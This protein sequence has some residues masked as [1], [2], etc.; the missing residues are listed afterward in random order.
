MNE[1]DTPKRWSCFSCCP[2][3]H[4]EE[5]SSSREGRIQVQ[6]VANMPALPIVSAESPV[7]TQPGE[8]F[9]AA[10]DAI[11]NLPDATTS[12]R[13]AGSQ[14][15]KSARTAGSREDIIGSR[16]VGCVNM[17]SPMGVQP[18]SFKKDFLQRCQDSMFD[19]TG[20]YAGAVKQR[21]EENYGRDNLR[22]FKIFSIVNFII[23]EYIK[24]H[25]DLSPE[26]VSEYNKIKKTLGD[27]LKTDPLNGKSFFSN[28]RSDA[29]LTKLK[30]M[31][32]AMKKCIDILFYK[33]D[34]GPGD[35]MLREFVLDFI[36]YF[37]F[38]KDVEKI[39]KI[40]NRIGVLKFLIS[41]YIHALNSGRD[42]RINCF[43]R[44]NDRKYIDNLAQELEFIRDYVEHLVMIETFS[45]DVLAIERYVNEL[46]AVP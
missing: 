21:F 8:R 1:I 9:A 42:L 26:G 36:L 16:S 6:S 38:S 35:F 15:G 43:T 23:I 17:L 31:A 19:L 39:A 41:P 22:D 3:S 24:R 33:N 40:S 37:N 2:L 32:Q 29:S 28:M 4:T 27:I 45:K 44:D 11:A 14:Q 20:K 46:P 34:F 13:A 25:D 7:S 5:Q 12:D 30:K 10:V 18:D